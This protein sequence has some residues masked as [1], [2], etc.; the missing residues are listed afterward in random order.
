MSETRTTSDR[1]DRRAF[2]QLLAMARRRAR[3]ARLGAKLAALLVALALAS[4][5]A[6]I[7]ALTRKDAPFEVTTGTIRVLLLLDLVFLLALAVLIAKPL[8]RLWVARRQGLAGSKLHGRIVRIF[9]LIAVGPSILMAIFTAVFFEFGIQ[10]WFSDTV[11]GTLQDSLVVAESYV[12]EHRQVIQGDILAMAIDLNRQAPFVQQDRRLLQALVDDQTAKRALSEAIVFTGDGI[13]LARST[14]NLE[15]APERV[16][17]VVMEQL[18]QGNLVLVS[19]TEDDRVR[20]LV[21]LENFVDAYLYVSRFVNSTVMNHAEAARA[22]V[23]EYESLEGERSQIQLRANFVFLVVAILILLIAVWVGLSLAT[24]LVAPIAKL[25]EAAEQVGKGNLNVRV[26]AL[27]RTDELG[28]LSRTFNRMTKQLSGQ[29]EDLIKANRQLD[30]RRRFTEAVLSGV[31]AAVIGLDKKGTINLPNRVAC[32]FLGAEA[33]E[34]EGKRLDKLLPELADCFRELETG[35]T[36][37]VQR[38]IAVSRNGSPRMLSVRIARETGDRSAGSYVVTFDDITDQLSDQRTAAWAD[39]ARRI[40]HEIKNPLTPIQLSAER[41]KRKYRGEITTDPEVFEQCTDTIIRQVADLRRMVDEF[42]SFARMPEPLFRTEDIVD[43]VRQAVFLQEVG[44][45]N[46]DFHL[47]LPDEMLSMV[48]DGRLIAQALTNV[49]KNSVESIASRRGGGL[50]AANDRGAIDITIVRHDTGKLEIA[51]SDNGAGLPTDIMERLTEP[52]V[53]TRAKGTGLGLAIVRK[54]VEDHHGHLT[55]QNR[56]A[57]G[58]KVTMQFDLAALER[59]LQP[60]TGQAKNR[61]RKKS[62]NKTKRKV[63]HGA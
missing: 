53:T 26:P 29:Q 18:N 7:I 31:S 60:K 6:T 40:A 12:K 16:P 58:A 51:V 49:I 42:S 45:P 54:V 36:E 52:Y 35:N 9:S 8:S 55:L 30:A 17:E 32:E 15:L 11:R 37:T 25:I 4:G 1:F 63:G 44:T 39:V 38:Q 14:L 5:A 19:E 13:V 10:S 33:T 24:Q 62:A 34:L 23:R 21:A 57:A 47:D 20:A 48:C 28:T 3:E 27:P 61:G 2:L 56:A 46:I 22:S 50:G 41:L 43:I 59:K